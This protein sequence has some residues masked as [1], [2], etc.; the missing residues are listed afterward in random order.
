MIEHSVGSLARLV[1]NVEAWPRAMVT[2]YFN[3]VELLDSGSYNMEQSV[4]ERYKTVHVLEIQYIE[5]DHFGVY[6]CVAANDYGKQFAT[7]RLVE[8]MPAYRSNQIIS[9]EGKQTTILII[10]GASKF[11]ILLR[12]LHNFLIF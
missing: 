6:S 12:S 5:R 7:I 11:T 9:V 1:C 2:W 10:F 4:T 8:S 3:D